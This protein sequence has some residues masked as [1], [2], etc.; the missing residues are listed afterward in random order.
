MIYELNWIECGLPKQVQW[1]YQQPGWADKKN[2]I[3][4]SVVSTVVW[5][6]GG[7]TIDQMIQTESAHA[8]GIAPHP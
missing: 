8:R 6:G 7:E 1:R 5:W 3:C 2:Y 4:R